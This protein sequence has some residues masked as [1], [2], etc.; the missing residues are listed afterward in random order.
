MVVINFNDQLQPVTFEHPI[1]YLINHKLDLSIFNSAYNNDVTGRLAYDPAIL[2][3]I[4]L[5]SL[6][7]LPPAAKC[8]GVVKLIFT[9][10]ESAKMATGKGTI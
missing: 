5:F 8:N 4:I 6:E 1:H 7:A 10:N 2:L 3:S 9:D